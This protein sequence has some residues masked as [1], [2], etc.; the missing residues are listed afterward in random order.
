MRKTQKK[1]NKRSGE[2]VNWG[3]LSCILELEGRKSV[4]V[5]PC[6]VFS[7][8]IFNVRHYVWYCSLVYETHN[9]VSVQRRKT[10]L[11][12][13]QCLV[14]GITASTSMDVPDILLNRYEKLQLLVSGN[15]SVSQSD[16]AN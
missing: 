12:R 1:T 16:A 7:P 11:S 13:D 4:K 15:H 14:V 3:S 10:D 2:N 6:S 8:I 5:Y 9:N